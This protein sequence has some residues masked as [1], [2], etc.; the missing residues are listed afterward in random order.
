MKRA[1]ARAARAIKT[2]MKRAMARKRVME[3]AAR[4]IATVTRVGGNKEGNGKG[5]KGDGDSNEDGE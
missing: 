3:R 5:S 4:A 1:M 2:A